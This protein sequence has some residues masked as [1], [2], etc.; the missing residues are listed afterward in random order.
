MDDLIGKGAI[1]HPRT[2]KAK[3]HTTALLRNNVVSYSGNLY[4]PNF[5]VLRWFAGM[6]DLRGPLV[7]LVSHILGVCRSIDDH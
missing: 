7:P 1:P 2:A 6:T 3:L 5:H 4:E